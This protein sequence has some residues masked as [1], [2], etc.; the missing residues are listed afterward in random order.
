MKKKSP[1]DYTMDAEEIAKSMGMTVH[2]FLGDEEEEKPQGFFDP[3]K[4]KYGPKI[5][6]KK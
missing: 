1:Q 2:E 6:E 3:S 5:S 4:L